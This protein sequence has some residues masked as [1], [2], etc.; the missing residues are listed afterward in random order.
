M[1]TSPPLLNQVPGLLFYKLMGSGKGKAFSIL[2]DFGRYGLL[3]TWESEAAANAFLY[4]SELMQTYRQHTYETWTLRMYPLQSHGYW[5]KKTPFEPVLAA[6]PAVGPVAVLTRASVNWL[7]LPGFLR[8]G[9][10]TTK[11]LDQAEGLLCS[12]GLGELPLV[13]QATFSVWESVEAMKA[14]AYR[15]RS[16]QEVIK[17]TRLENWYSEELFARFAPVASEGTWH[18]ADPLGQVLSAKA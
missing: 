14:Y 10:Q 11:A 16:H 9:L 8:F 3:C 4:D 5:D 15:Q 6:P 17:R 12:I 7:A 13:R 18:G 2:P 1:G